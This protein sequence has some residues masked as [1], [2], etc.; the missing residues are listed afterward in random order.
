[1]FCPYY[2]VQTYIQLQQ[3]SVIESYIYV[4]VFMCELTSVHA[5]ISSLL[6]SHT[7]SVCLFE[8]QVVVV[9]LANALCSGEGIKTIKTSIHS[10]SMVNKGSS[11]TVEKQIE[12]KNLFY[13]AFRITTGFHVPIYLQTIIFSKIICIFSSIS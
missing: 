5:S 6:L 11:T 1:M 4:Y 10:D 13:C 2:S 7:T 9:E 8:H 3:R 12:N